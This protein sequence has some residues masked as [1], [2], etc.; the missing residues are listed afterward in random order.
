MITFPV[1]PDLPNPCGLTPSKESRKKK[2][3]I[4]FV[5]PIYSV[6]HGQTP[7]GQSLKE[8]SSP[9]LPTSARS[10]SYGELYFSNLYPNF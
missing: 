4:Q 6:E 1:F 8:N 2:K 5:L 10:H 3:P 9:S 7:N